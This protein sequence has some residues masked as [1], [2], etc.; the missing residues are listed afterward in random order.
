M[1]RASSLSGADDNMD[2]VLVPGSGTWGLAG[3]ELRP[4]RLSLVILMGM[5]YLLR[6]DFGEKNGE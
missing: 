6:K 1:P 4:K 3:L 5:T 2:S